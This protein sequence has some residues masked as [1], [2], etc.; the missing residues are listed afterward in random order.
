MEHYISTTEL[1]DWLKITTNDYYHIK[2]HSGFLQAKE[3]VKR[4]LDILAR[5]FA[6]SVCGIEILVSLTAIDHLLFYFKECS[7]TKRPFS[8][9][10]LSKYSYSCSKPCQFLS[11][12]LNK[13]QMI[14]KW[15]SIFLNGLDLYCEN[16]QFDRT[17]PTS[18]F[19]QTPTTIFFDC[20]IQRSAFCLEL[21]EQAY[22]CIHASLS[23]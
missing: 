3:C 14:Q 2:C 18:R 20:K 21:Q 12:S 7:L 11:F 15:I 5:F 8:H 9:L 4:S 17:H 10:Y 13:L 19:M 23:I 22:Q 1:Q 16:V 6:V